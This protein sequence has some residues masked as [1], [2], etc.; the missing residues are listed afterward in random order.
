MFLCSCVNIDT[1]SWYFTDNLLKKI[2]LRYLRENIPVFL[3]I[4]LFFSFI[5]IYKH[6]NCSIVKNMIYQKSLKR[7]GLW[8]FKNMSP[9]SLIPLSSGG[10]VWFHFL[11]MEIKC[12]RSD[13]PWILI[14]DPKSSA[15]SAWLSAGTFALGT[16]TP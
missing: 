1:L 3:F 6:F 12:S 4:F 8:R 10:G 15:T 9:E 7:E 16:L 2:F 5:K 11:W 13:A 14:L